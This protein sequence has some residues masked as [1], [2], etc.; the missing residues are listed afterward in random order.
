MGTGVRLQA[1]ASLPH[2]S[3]PAPT[4]SSP[5]ALLPQATT[6]PLCSRAMLCESAP[7]IAVTLLTPSTATGELGLVVVPSPNWLVTL[8]PTAGTEPASSSRGK[9]P[10]REGT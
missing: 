5:S 9:W 8:L 3:G 10:A 2:V 7:E 4:P 1:I 6:V